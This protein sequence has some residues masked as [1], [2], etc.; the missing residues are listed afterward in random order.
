MTEIGDEITLEGHAEWFNSSFVHSR[1]NG[2]AGQ[3]D[4]ALRVKRARIGVDYGWALCGESWWRA[5]GGE[6]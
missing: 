4:A 1:S 5:A 6:R 3:R 2:I